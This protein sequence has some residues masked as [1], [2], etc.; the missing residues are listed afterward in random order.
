[1]KTGI[2]ST[3]SPI[4][5]VQFPNVFAVSVFVRSLALTVTIR[6]S[7]V[8]GNYPLTALPLLHS[9]VKENDKQNET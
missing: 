9:V 4:Q 1:M 3:G 2:S 8:A 6:H 5:R 7:I